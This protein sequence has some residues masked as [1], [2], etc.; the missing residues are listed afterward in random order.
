MSHFCGYNDASDSLDAPL[1]VGFL[2][3]RSYSK[4]QFSNFTMKFNKQKAL[5]SHKNN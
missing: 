1:L 5:T 4:T 2:T 3:S